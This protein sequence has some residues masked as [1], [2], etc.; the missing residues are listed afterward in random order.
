MELRHL[1]KEKKNIQMDKISNEIICGLDTRDYENIL[2]HAGDKDNQVIK[3]VSIVLA[4]AYK[5]ESLKANLSKLLEEMSASSDE[6]VRKTMVLTAGEIGK[7]N[8]EDIFPILEFAMDDESEV[9]Q[10]TAISALKIMCDKNPGPSLKLASSLIG[11]ENPE[12]RKG[13]IHGLELRGKKYPEDVLPIL[14]AIQNEKHKSVVNVI[15]HVM[16]RIS[17]RKGSVEKVVEE[18]KTWTN[19]WL[20]KKSAQEIISFHGKHTKFAS[21]SHE[22]IEK[23]LTENGCFEK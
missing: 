14:T 13:I 9:V 17:Y 20:V 21:R 5:D 2:N 7:K 3:H 18:L 22:E 11:H 4:D 8:A 23:Y 12:I 15:I 16:G 6:K 10:K 1:S 19:R